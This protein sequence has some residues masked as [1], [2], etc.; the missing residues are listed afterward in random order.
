[1]PV[2]GTLTEGE[3]EIDEAMLTGE[4]LP[5]SKAA[6][7]TVFGGTLNGSGSF[8]M[9]ATAVGAATRLSQIVALVG[10]AQRSRAPIQALADRVAAW[11][12]PLVVLIAVLSFV[13]WLLI[14][15]DVSQA[16]VAA[17]SVLIIACPCALGLATP[18]S[19]MVATGRGAH[20]GVL[21]KDARALEA[22]A[23]ADTLV[24][25]KTGTL[26]EGR[27]VLDQVVADKGV[28]EGWVLSIAAALERRSAHPLARAIA[29]GAAARNA[30]TVEVIGFRSVTGKGVTGVL[31][32]SRVA[33]GNAAMMDE[34]KVPVSEAFAALAADHAGKGRTAMFVAEGGKLIGL[35]TATD[36]VKPGAKAA[37]DA[38]RTEGFA[39]V[40]ATGDA[41]GTA[42]AVGRAL[43]VDR[44]EAGMTPEGKH[45]LVVRLHG[46]GKRVVFAGD[47][48][49]DGPALAAADVGIAMG[50]GS[51]VAIE[52]AGITLLKGDLA[53]AARARRLARATLGNIRQNL[54]LAFGYNAI[55]IPVAAGVLYP[56]TGWLLS[57]MI[58]A[59]AMSLSSVSVIGN[60]LRLQRLAL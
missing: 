50:R 7:A 52:S 14:T 49:N 21:V 25:D 12:V 60:A 24:I 29:E 30:R 11:F 55:C 3:S 34:L 36:P 27:P 6:G 1:V 48:I 37:L 17:I 35:V 22:L 51:D 42:Q 56:I 32:G 45:D 13:A 5:A 10:K 53:G 39:I 54:W 43:G 2:D 23:T 4:P 15:R 20:A 57:P 28:D 59:A 8:V 26:T 47:G 9:R 16:L 40:M 18:M 58:A 33:L 38:L 44:I 41:P 19:V 46:E 31:R